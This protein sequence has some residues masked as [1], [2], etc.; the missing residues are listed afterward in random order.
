MRPT[1]EG[2]PIL[3]TECMSATDPL[4]SLD[5]APD[6]NDYDEMPYPSMPFAYTQPSHLAA[7][8][9]LFG[10]DAPPVDGARVLELGCASGGNIIPLA[11]R[12]PQARFL[13]IDLSQRHIDNGQRRIAAL[14]VE[15]IQLRQGDLTEFSSV[16]DF[17]YVICHGVFS[18]VPK[19]T[20]DAIFR[21][22]RE[23]L[24]PTGVATIS[25]NVLP[26]W[27]LRQIV[28]GICLHHTGKRGPPRE[29]VSKARF[30]LDQVARSSPKS[31][32]YGILL[33][34]EAE[35][36]SRL[37]AS[38]MLGE[39][40]AADNVPCYFHEFAERATQYGLDFLCEGDFESS[41]SEAVSAQAHNNVQTA[42][43]SSR[44]A[45]EQYKDFVTGRYFRRSV[46]IRSDQAAKPAIKPKPDQLRLL[47]IASHLRP[48]PDQPDGQTSVYRD[49]Q[50][51]VFTAKDSATRR[52]LSHLAKVYPSTLS[53]EQL[54]G[55]NPQGDA[56][57][58]ETEAH[59][60]DALFALIAAKHADCSS[61][62]L[63]VGRASEEL[64]RAWSVARAEAAARQPWIT[65]LRHEAIPLRP[66]V[67][68]V[69]PH[70]NGRN[71]RETLKALLADALRRGEITVTEL[72]G[73]GQPENALIERVA[74][75]YIDHLLEYLELHAILEP[76]DS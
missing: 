69:L 62:P 43:S 21:I 9:A 58:D 27:H 49:A 37:P 5:G 64:P 28:R 10:L 60:S 8:A 40:L 25:Y 30:I 56:S 13:G 51:R 32:P 23:S 47:Q 57:S 41:I 14:G 26:G 68:F 11:K 24:A 42:A 59:L 3:W 73:D 67:A 52:A 54:R 70:L 4:E 34:N 48:A 16:G 6:A 33:R 65:S 1:A 17:D 2:V 53:F 75:Q 38:Y 36:M 50:G 29:R 46:L 72:K 61:V 22:C 45:L 63:R 35:R 44:V 66:V 74:A 19:A 18:W 12:F 7:L 20:Q 31:T 71:N 15:N 39:F 76:T 55:A